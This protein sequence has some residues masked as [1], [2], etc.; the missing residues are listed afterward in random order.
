MRIIIFGASGSG[1]TTL[2]STL[3]TL[4]NYRHLDSDDYYW[5]KTDE[6][7]TQKRSPELRNSSFMVDLRLENNVIVSG[8]VFGWGEDFQEIFDLAVFLWIPQEIR[9]ARL[10]EREKLRYGDL[11]DTD[12]HYKN[13]CAE[14]LEWA[15]GYDDPDFKSRSLTLHNRWI[16]KLEIPVLRIEGD[17]SVAERVM[18]VSNKISAMESRNQAS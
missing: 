9:L 12:I 13:K 16:E 14:F 8:P 4:L 17:T 5:L 6:A 10:L 2:A 3:S 18:I 7:F 11:L 1:T 15:A